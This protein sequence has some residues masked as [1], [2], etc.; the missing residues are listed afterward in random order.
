M[1]VLRLPSPNQTTNPR[2]GAMVECDT[3]RF[4]SPPVTQASNIHRKVQSCFLKRPQRQASA[5]HS[6]RVSLDRPAPA[7][8]CVSRVT[9]RRL[10]PKSILGPGSRCQG[11]KGPGHTRRRGRREQLAAGGAGG[12]VEE[13][14]VR[15]AA[16]GN[17]GSEHDSDAAA[18]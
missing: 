2:S 6:M 7:G 14:R 12:G 4:S 13:R 9:S 16:G 18:A 15:R 5:Q 8:S 11:P 3:I 10:G 17:R 1:I